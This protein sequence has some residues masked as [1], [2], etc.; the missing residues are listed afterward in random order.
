MRKRE[1][2]IYIST[3][4][5]QRRVQRIGKLDKRKRERDEDSERDTSERKKGRGKPKS[6]I[7]ITKTQASGERQNTI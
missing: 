7:L 4:E 2:H 3:S 5:S 1:I 6:R